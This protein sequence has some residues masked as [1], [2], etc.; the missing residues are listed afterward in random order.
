MHPYYQNNKSKLRREMDGYLKLIRPEIE[1]IFGKPY[2]QVFSE[3][4]NDYEQEMLEHFPFIGGDRSSGT[5]NLTGCMFFVSIGVV[6]KQY[7][8]ST[9]NWGRLVTTLYERYFERVPK[10]L[11]RLVGGLLNCCPDLINKALRRKDKKNAENAAKNPGSFVT[12]TMTPTAEYPVIYHNQVCPIYE[13]CKERG[14][15]GVSALYVQ[16]GLCDVPGF[17]CYPVPGKDLCDR[18]WTM[19]LQDEAGCTHSRCVAASYSG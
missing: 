6:G 3:I 8:L 16:P 18:G 2:P 17:W 12:Q 9:R 4:W 13:F 1:E 14:I 5:R 7:G 19:R 15:H 11:R 10:P